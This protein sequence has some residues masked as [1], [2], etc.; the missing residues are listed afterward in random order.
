MTGIMG[1]FY[2]WKP[3]AI[4]NLCRKHKTNLFQC[5][6]GGQMDDALDILDSIAVAITVAEPA[7]DEGGGPRPDKGHETVVSIPC[8]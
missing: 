7:I 4:V 5:H 1:K 3:A 6:F 8:V 2:Q